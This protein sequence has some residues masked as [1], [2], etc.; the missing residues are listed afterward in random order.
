MAKIQ[1]LYEVAENLVV[2]PGATP[3]IE[4]RPDIPSYRVKLYEGN[5]KYSNTTTTIKFAK[6]TEKEVLP[7]LQAEQVALI[8]FDYAQKNNYT[9]EQ[10]NGLR[11][12]LGAV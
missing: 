3:T 7:G 2:T 5:G 6:E 9:T 11:A 12:F 1:K 10:I 8:L 4:V